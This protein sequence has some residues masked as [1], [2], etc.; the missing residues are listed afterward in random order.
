MR[1]INAKVYDY[2][3]LGWMNQ[4]HL[5]ILVA[6]KPKFDEAETWIHRTADV[7]KLYDTSAEQSTIVN[8][9]SKSAEPWYP[10]GNGTMYY[11][12]K[13]GYVRFFLHNPKNETGFGGAT[14]RGVLEDGTG[15]AVK[16]PW[17]SNPDAVRKVF[18]IDTL[19]VSM[20]ED[21]ETFY[22]KGYSW[23]GG[24]ITLEFAKRAIPFLLP[25][26][27]ITDTPP[28]LTRLT[29]LVPQYPVGSPNWN[30]R[31]YQRKKDAGML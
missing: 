26:F 15:F 25:D 11:A 9:G 27:T 22:A 28:Y 10:K 29:P 13:G 16:G 7:D 18:G 21:E 14:F 5:Q 12:E 4:P 6:D 2:P 30:K 8:A 20:T 23:L 17:S 1:L 24:H 3:A 19:D 31:E